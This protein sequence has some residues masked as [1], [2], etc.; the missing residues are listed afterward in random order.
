MTLIHQYFSTYAGGPNCRLPIWALR[1]GEAGVR[2]ISRIFTLSQHQPFNLLDAPQSFFMHAKSDAY[3]HIYSG[4]QD[5]HL[6]VLFE[7][8]WS[9]T[10]TLLE[11]IGYFLNYLA[12]WWRTACTRT[13]KST[14]ASRS[15]DDMSATISTY[16]CFASATWSPTFHSK[17]DCLHS[18]LLY[19]RRHYVSY[20]EISVDVSSQVSPLHLSMPW[21]A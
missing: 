12:R 9:T 16:A 2:R 20:F 5:V 7:I 1:C 6:T 4:Q 15:Q 13:T 21:L 19:S 11:E 14:K 17:R 8:S 10:S 3:V 18:E